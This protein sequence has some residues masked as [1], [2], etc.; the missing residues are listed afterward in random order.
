M[1]SFQAGLTAHWRE[2]LQKM[3]DARKKNVKQWFGI[4]EEI[5]DR[6][7]CF[8]HP[9]SLGLLR[10]PIRVRDVKRRESLLHE[11]ASEG[12]GV[13]PVY[14][15]SI[16]HLPELRGE[17]PAKSFPV[18]ESCARELVTLPTHEYLTQKDMT[19]IRRLL[20]LALVARGYRSA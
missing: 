3:R 8:Q 7:S 12:A 4:L 13:T 1:S 14:P 2:K 5:G 9:Q 20:S 11:S 17:I 15:E 18:A 10:F 16:N 6:G 19:V